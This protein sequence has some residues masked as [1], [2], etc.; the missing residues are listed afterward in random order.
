MKK[1]LIVSLLAIT[2]FGGT[3]SI[4]ASNVNGSSGT[5]Q[6]TVPDFSPQEPSTEMPGSDISVI[7]TPSTIPPTNEDNTDDTNNTGSPTD[8]GKSTVTAVVTVAPHWDGKSYILSNGS[9]ATGIYKIN[10]TYY[11]FDDNGNQ[12]QYS[13]LT[14]A[15]IGTDRYC[16]NPNGTAASGWQVIRN[17]LYY[18]KKNG[19]VLSN[20]TYHNIT[21]AKDGHAK[22][23]RQT[24]E[25]IQAISSK[26][27]FWKKYSDGTY[28]VKANGDRAVGLF[29]IQGKHYVFRKN[30]KLKTSSGNYIYTSD[31]KVYGIGTNGSNLSGW[32]MIKNNLYYFNKDGRAKSNTTYLGITFAQDGH[33][34]KVNG[35]D[36]KAK[37]TAMKIYN[38]ITTPSM[39]KS[40]K[41]RACWNYMTNKKNFVYVS[42]Y[43]DLN[44]KGWQQATAYDMLSTRTGNCYS[45][46]CAFAALA[47]ECG[48]DAQIVCG[49]VSGSRDHMP[50][51]L[52][53]HCWVRINGRYYDPEGAFAGWYRNCYD[54]TNY[55]GRHTIQKI[56][57]YKTS[58]TVS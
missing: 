18:A 35:C 21:F 31:N 28:Y 56:V 46:A 53:R 37:F 1:L 26:K 3:H 15:K 5:T 10:G 45:F 40:Q 25:R 29:K 8:T 42:K 12:K 49:R 9:K 41:L 20:T 23:S 58:R 32:H 50:D 52:T 43:P 17:K 57:V 4:L 2:L 11:F 22:S 38:R 48:Y 6:E 30:G 19:K 34:K 47:C 16:I 36:P 39:S 7:E 13:Q 55:N 44:K 51:G 33:A 24:K 27:G 14:L 54:S